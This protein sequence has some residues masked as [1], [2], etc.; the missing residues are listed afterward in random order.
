MLVCCQKKEY[1][2]QRFFQDKQSSWKDKKQ[3]QRY[4]VK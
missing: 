1:G 3:V 2:S 4:L